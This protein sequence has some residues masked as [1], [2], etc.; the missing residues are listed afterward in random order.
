MRQLHRLPLLLAALLAACGAAAPAPASPPSPAR[1][2][3]ADVVALINSGDR[4]AARDFIDRHYS[5]SLRE[6]KPTGIHLRTLSHIHV[7]SQGL[8]LAEVSEPAPR[9]AEAVAYSELTEHW[10]RVSVELDAKP[11]HRIAAL[12]ARPIPAP[13]G[14][15]AA[16]PRTDE[17]RA[18]M[19]DRYVRRL[20]DAGIFSGVVMLAKE[21]K[22]VFTAAYGEAN[23]DMHRPNTA[24]TAFNLASVN[25]MMTAVAIAQLVEAGKLT[26]DDPLSKFTPDYPNPRDARRIRI[27]HLL[28]HTAGL[29]DFMQRGVLNGRAGTVDGLLRYA[30]DAEPAFAP[31][32]RFQYSN[33]GYLLLGK[34]IERA[35]GEDYYDYMRKHVF[36]P[37]GMRSAAFHTRER[38]PPS[39]AVGYAH[40]YERPGV[41]VSHRDDLP[42]RGS[43]AGGGYAT[44][45]D[46]VRFTEALRTGRLVSPAMVRV[47]T[48]P[49]PALG[50]PDYGF[51]FMMNPRGGM[52]G[53]TGGFPGVANFVDLTLDDGYT[54]VVLS[55][56][57]DAAVLIAERMRDMLR[58]PAPPM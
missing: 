41:Y 44:A 38:I 28:S 55:N 51:G 47:L 10:F 53:H 21:G 37:A 7:L 2:R 16:L 36:L 1:A 40:D 13:A 12:T 34:L 32:T 33:T 54:A 11:P 52:V 4:D 27:K 25:K 26:F 5:D 50:S 23:R 8:R 22:P 18:R 6:S 45:A 48:T 43:P 9:R 3:A 30:N 58:G 35:S 20:A 49:K 29:G 15:A 39:V 57:P 14:R 17:E 24:E 56:Q 31:G 42:F 19:L 46:I